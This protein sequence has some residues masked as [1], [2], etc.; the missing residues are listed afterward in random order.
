MRKI[1]LALVFGFAVIASAGTAAGLYLASQD[2]D[3]DNERQ[4]ADAQET[5]TPKPA[6]TEGPGATETQ[7]AEP[8]VIEPDAIPTVE[9][10]ASPTPTP[11]P[12]ATPEFGVCPTPVRKT[13]GDF[14]QPPPIRPAS[15]IFG[16]R[17]Q[18]GT[19]HTV[20]YLTVHLPAGREFAIWSGWT[21]SDGQSMM[22]IDVQTQST[23]TLRGD[24]CEDYRF[25]RD[26][27]ADTV[28]DEIVDSVEVSS[29]YVCPPASRSTLALEEAPV[30][31]SGVSVSGGEAYELPW[32]GLAL[33]LPAGREF[34]VWSGLADPG[35][36]FIGIYDVSAR[37]FLFLGPDGCEMSRRV[38]DPTAD[39][40]LDEIVATLEVE[41]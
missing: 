26:P 25:T 34:Q 39:A 27:A 14:E 28:F 3:A 36:A 10:P 4:V 31:V 16:Q 8:Y 1:A 23:L 37:S 9:P 32:Y 15:E 6:L 21:R 13:P 35:G 7:E 2:G 5:P 38:A 33:H 41:R 29:A 19:S 20:G 22:V 18:G 12:T 11:M 17:V 30:A 40:I 24:G